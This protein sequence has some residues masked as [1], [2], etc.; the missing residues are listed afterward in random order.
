MLQLGATIAI[1]RASTAP[2]RPLPPPWFKYSLSDSYGVMLAGAAAVAA[3]GGG[4]LAVAALSQGQAN[5]VGELNCM[6]GN[7]A[8]TGFSGLHR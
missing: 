1:L 3:A 4:V 7:L 8:V 2:H 6:L 5:G